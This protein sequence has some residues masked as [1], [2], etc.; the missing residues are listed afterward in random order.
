MAV[1]SRTSQL[2]KVQK[3][4]K[5][6][7]QTVAPDP[8]R[9]V[10]E[11]LVFACCLENAHY[12]RAE[13]AFAALEHN[14]FDWNEIR[15]TTIRELSEVMARLPDPPAA[16]NR[17]KRVL[18]SVF[19]STYSYDLEEL[20]K[21][22][23][24]PAVELLR[25]IDGTTNFTVAYATQAALGGHAIPVDEGVLEALCVVGLITEK[26]LEAGAVSG[27][28][29]AI[30]KSKGLEFASQLHQLG[31]DF[32]DDPCA[33]AVQQI[34]L[35]INPDAR[36]RLPK[37]RTRK[38]SP[39]SAQS[40]ERSPAQKEAKRR[41]RRDQDEPAGH[42]KKST[43]RKAE[44]P[45]E[46]PAGG[47][48]GES[49]QNADPQ[50]ADPQK[51]VSGVEAHEEPAAKKRPPQGKKKAAAN[52]EGGAAEAKTQPDAGPRKSASARLSKRKP[53]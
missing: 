50:A 24:G 10:F 30:A 39:A 40:S 41:R 34:L 19:E 2:N 33:H 9:S 32:V 46:K 37:R 49:G 15:V 7:Y 18:Q 16:A 25:K 51:E 31:A 21:K 13:E 43:G 6:H 8:N 5:K 47:A 26:D 20:R 42:K 44:T 23:L 17:V 12:D 52:K 1:P 38:R 45:E 22:N 11:Q 3:V 14:F 53:R 48:S 27:L 35:E 4:L 28:E 29:R 36:D